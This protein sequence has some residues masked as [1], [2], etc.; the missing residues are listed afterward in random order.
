M[1]LESLFEK[2]ADKIRIIKN[3]KNPSINL[4]EID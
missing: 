4:V 3:N 1:H 2:Y